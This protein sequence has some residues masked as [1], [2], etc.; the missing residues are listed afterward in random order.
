[1][2]KE[3][4]PIKKVIKTE[5]RKTESPTGAYSSVNS[6]KRVTNERTNTP[7]DFTFNMDNIKWILISTGLVILGYFLMM[8]GRMPSPDVW[9]DKIIYSFRRTVI[10][11]VFIL[12]GLGLAIYAI[13]RNKPSE[14]K[15]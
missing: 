14:I 13:F 9:D 4:T 5:T 12:T 8:G 1:M 3:S 15:S 2:A 7:S 11:P 6:R 10:A